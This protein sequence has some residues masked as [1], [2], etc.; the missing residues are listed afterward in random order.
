MY[1]N[2]S[3]IVYDHYLPR[4]SSIFTNGRTVMLTKRRA[5][6]ALVNLSRTILASDTYDR[7]DVHYAL[8]KTCLDVSYCLNHDSLDTLIQYGIVKLLTEVIHSRRLWVN[9]E[10]KSSLAF[11]LTV[12]LLVKLS[13][14]EYVN[15]QFRVINGNIDTEHMVSLDEILNEG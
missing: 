7:K 4:V 9:Y 11:R 8:Y 6:N 14:Y 3:G 13:S 10:L 15:A 2:E 12:R 5:T 1:Y